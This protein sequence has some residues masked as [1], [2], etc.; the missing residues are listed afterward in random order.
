MYYLSDTTNVYNNCNDI[1]GNGPF[2]NYNIYP[3]NSKSSSFNYEP[4]INGFI[5]STIISHISLVYSIVLVD[6]ID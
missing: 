2:T 6:T 5:N 4:I 1:D 3:I